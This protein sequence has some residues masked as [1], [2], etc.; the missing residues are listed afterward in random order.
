M[1]LLLLGAAILSGIFVGTS[2]IPYQPWALFF[3]YV[4]LWSVI[5]I[6]ENAQENT[7]AT[8]RLNL[9]FIFLSC[10]LTQFILTLIG[11]NWIYFVATEFGHL[12]TFIAGAALFLFSSLM[13]IYI[14]LAFTIA[15]YCKRRWNLTLFQL[16]LLFALFLSLSERLWPSIFPWHL[17]YALLWMKGPFPQL[18]QWA[19]TIGFAGLSTII[20]LIQAVITIALVQMKKDPLS[21]TIKII[22]VVVMLFGFNIG[23]KA[24]QKAWTNFDD[25]LRLSVIQGNIG[26]DEKLMAEKGGNFQSYVYQVHADLVQ[27]ELVN[28]PDI[29]LWP[30]TAMPFALDPHWSNRTNQQRLFAAIKAWNVPLITGG[31]SQ[32]QFER[33]HTGELKIRNSVFFLGPQGQQD[34]PYFKSQLLVFGEYMPLGKEFP[35][36]YKILPFVGVYEKG[37][38]PVLKKV[39]TAQGKNFN[40]GPQICYESLDPHFSRGLSEAGADLLF[41]VTN[42]SWFGDW[43]EPYQH[44]I[45][46]L[47]RGVEVRRPLLRSTNT[48][49]STVI[50]ANGKILDQSP[51]GQAW[52]HTYTVPF[53]RNN[54]TT[55][56]TQCGHWDWLIWVAI[57]ILIFIF[58]R[59]KRHVGI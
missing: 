36:L 4:P 15:L 47:A 46:T 21:S 9:R 30:E 11:F 1:K 24:K 42:D 31:Y 25:E 2:Y 16:A 55:F 52:S 12:P 35:F 10:W 3:C 17:G 37:P 40:L 18:F 26:N 59:K 22:F 6:S 32:D 19:D 45:M 39:Q 49:I 28:S 13:H 44:M 50:L 43:A 34:S 57:I 33:D 53:K 41:N 8:P 38:G 5:L 20:L 54:D 58:Q 56:F 51:I 29:V 7:T 23:G 14:P 48:G 27:K